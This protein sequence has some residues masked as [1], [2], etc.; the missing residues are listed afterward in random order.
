MKFLV[1]RLL[2][3]AVLPAGLLLCH[4]ALAAPASPPLAGTVW[5]LARYGQ[6]GHLTPALP[7]REVTVV[8][9]DQG[10]LTGSAGC[11]S[12]FAGFK[13]EGNRMAVTAAGATKMFCGDPPGLMVQENQYLIALSSV[14]RYKIKGNKLKLFTK[15]GQKLVF[16]AR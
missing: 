15:D 12:Y 14:E 5:V 16:T 10:R 3:Y 9:G 2:P 6:P 7:G 4:P 8:F 11:N 1:T 13:T